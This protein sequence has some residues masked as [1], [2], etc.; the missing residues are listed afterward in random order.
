[1]PLTVPAEAP[2]PY[3][4]LDNRAM[5]V[6][7][8]NRTVLFNRNQDRWVAETLK[9]IHTE[10]R[11]TRTQANH[12]LGGYLSSR[13]VVLFAG[14]LDSLVTVLVSHEAFDAL[15]AELPDA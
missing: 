8:G 14:P 5:V 4:H 7:N 1:M 9:I 15:R 12:A 10:Q 11:A 2:S 13:G 6:S 3:V